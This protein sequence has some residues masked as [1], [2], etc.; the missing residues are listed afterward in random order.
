MAANSLLVRDAFDSDCKP[1]DRNKQKGTWFHLQGFILSVRP[2][3]HDNIIS[4]AEVELRALHDVTNSYVL[5][6]AWAVTGPERRT[7]DLWLFQAKAN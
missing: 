5:K 4:M 1:K 7:S 6:D 3:I 2:S